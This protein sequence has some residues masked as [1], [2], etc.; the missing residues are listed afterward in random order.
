MK[1]VP[2]SNPEGEVKAYHC[3]KCEKIHYEKEYAENCCLCN[4][5]KKELDKNENWQCETCRDKAHME[6]RITVL[7]QAEDITDSDYSGPVFIE[8]SHDRYFGDIGEA[9]EHY[10]DEDEDAW[11]E[12][13]FAVEVK[14]F[15][16]D[17]WD[18]INSH[19]EDEHHEDFI[20]QMDD[21][22]ELQQF[23]EKW[24]TKQK[25]VSWWPDESKKIN[26]LKLIK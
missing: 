16:M 3:G 25:G 14:K 17:I 19:C 26:L 9:I 2:L 21:M 5:C 11:P 12:W 20:D 22:D 1:P 18:A 15:S 8:D 7:G 24:V 6:Y 13:C 10:L 23:W 4:T